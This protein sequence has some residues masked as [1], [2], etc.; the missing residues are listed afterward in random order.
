MAVQRI[1]SLGEWVGK[2]GLVEGNVITDGIGVENECL[3]QLYSEQVCKSWCLIF[4]KMEF[5]K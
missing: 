1:N 2:W 3:E 5:L 4:L